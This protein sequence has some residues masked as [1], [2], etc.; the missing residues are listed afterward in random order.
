MAQGAPSPRTRAWPLQTP[1]RA[2]RARCSRKVSGWGAVSG[3]AVGGG[4]TEWSPKEG[5]QCL[6][7]L[8]AVSLELQSATCVASPPLNVRVAWA[9]GSLKGV[10]SMPVVT[11]LLVQA[12]LTAE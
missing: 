3:G 10:R 11:H 1:L 8:L 4:G 6:A 5:A 7:L 12:T 9:G 2:C